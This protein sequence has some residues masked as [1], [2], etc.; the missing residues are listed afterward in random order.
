MAA[1]SSNSLY[2]L[3]I[4]Q[5]VERWYLRPVSDDL[6]TLTPQQQLSVRRQSV[7][8]WLQSVLL[9]VV[10]AQSLFAALLR[11]LPPELRNALAFLHRI[12]WAA[13]VAIALVVAQVITG[14]TEQIVLTNRFYLLAWRL[15]RPRIVSRGIARYLQVA[16]LIFVGLMIVAVLWVRAHGFLVQ[17]VQ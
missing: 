4:G 1:R 8:G 11:A 10:V 6:P 7:V 13:Y 5:P 16:Y 12:E 3:L 17:P 14:W 9:V 15:G 2:R